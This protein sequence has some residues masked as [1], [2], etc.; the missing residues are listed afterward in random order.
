MFVSEC[1]VVC[2]AV[3]SWLWLQS[4]LAL[5]DPNAQDALTQASLRR[6]AVLHM[7]AA[8]RFAGF[9]SKVRGPF[10]ACMHEGCLGISPPT[11]AAWG[12]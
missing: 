4:I 7:A 5:V 1:V 8:A 12:L 2:A 9:V 11:R 6:S 3:C 10:D